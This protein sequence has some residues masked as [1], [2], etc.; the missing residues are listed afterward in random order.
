MRSRMSFAI[1]DSLPKSISIME[2]VS[3]GLDGIVPFC[4]CRNCV[5]LGLL[6]HTFAGIRYRSM[7][8]WVGGGA[9]CGSIAGVLSSRNFVCPP[10]VPSKRKTDFSRQEEIKLTS[11]NVDL[12][13]CR[14]LPIYYN[15]TILRPRESKLYASLFSTSFRPT[16][17]FY[18]ILMM[19]STVHV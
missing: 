11:T 10:P 15:S 5:E 7:S 9:P 19:M 12:D 1:R 3:K 4:L 14:S 18:L 13:T 16:R 8:R 17:L 2:L 6:S